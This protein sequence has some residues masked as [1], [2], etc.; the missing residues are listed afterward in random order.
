M[1]EPYIIGEQRDGRKKHPLEKSGLNEDET[2]DTNR[3]ITT[4][5]QISSKKA[6]LQIQDNNYFI[7]TPTDKR[8]LTFSESMAHEDLKFSK[9]QVSINL[10]ENPEHNSDEI[11]K[12]IHKS[13]SFIDAQYQPSDQESP[14][15]T[16]RQS[17]RLIKQLS[18]PEQN[19]EGLDPMDNVSPRFVIR[20]PNGLNFQHRLFEQEDQ[21]LV[22][23]AQ[24]LKIPSIKETPRISFDEIE[25]LNQK[26]FKNEELEDLKE[27]TERFISNIRFDEQPF[28]RFRSE[29]TRS[30]FGGSKNDSHVI[31]ID[32]YE[33]LMIESPGSKSP[34]KSR[35]KPS[36][37]DETESIGSQQQ[38]TLLKPS[39]FFGKSF[40]GKIGSYQNEE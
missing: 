4:P 18:D 5:I 25:H 30:I 40:E 3:L 26:E 15:H 20:N 34:R 7:K 19:K 39:T 24:I 31:H 28:N 2:Q 23:K 37:L 33:K 32:D 9:S 29:S 10:P 12:E 6:S 35:F 38:S 21:N 13:I 22:Q 14:D 1:I 11:E 17:Q 36:D 8:T 16:D 27:S